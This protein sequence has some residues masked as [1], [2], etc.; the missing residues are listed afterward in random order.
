VA[1][2]AA[3]KELQEQLLAWDEELTWREEA[4][5]MLEDKARISEVALVKVSANL[6]VEQV[7][8]K[9]TRKEYLDKM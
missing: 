7:K 5:T 3:A 2:S 8:V 6:D 9:A 4:L 1:T